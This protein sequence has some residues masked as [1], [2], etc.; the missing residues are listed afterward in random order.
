MLL[1]F[2]S[3]SFT[4]AATWI[5]FAPIATITSHFYSVSLFWV[6]S[7]STVWPLLHHPPPLRAALCPLLLSREMNEGSQ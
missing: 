2:C 5:T 1:L 4:N 6:N 3:L 7:L